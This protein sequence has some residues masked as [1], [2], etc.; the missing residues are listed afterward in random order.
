ME[1]T[2]VDIPFLC[3]TLRLVVVQLLKHSTTHLG[4]NFDVHVSGNINYISCNI[5]K[6]ASASIDVFCPCE[7]SRTMRIQSR[8]FTQYAFPRELR[9]NNR[10]RRARDDFIRHL[11][12][13]QHLNGGNESQ[14]KA[15]EY[16]IQKYLVIK[17]CLANILHITDNDLFI[18]SAVRDSF[19]LVHIGRLAEI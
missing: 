11:A 19:L 13:I 16:V 3:Q 9:R 4:F 12:Q 1:L 18:M 7:E 10:A 5:G 8:T 2:C 17:Q 14:G 6:D 15:A